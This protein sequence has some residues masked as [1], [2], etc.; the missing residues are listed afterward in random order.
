M[1]YFHYIFVSPFISHCSCCIIPYRAQLCSVWVTTSSTPPP[2]EVLNDSVRKYDALRL[3]YI[4]AYID[5]ML[6]C[7]RKD[8]VE[9]LLTWA[10]TSQQDLPSFY[11]ASAAFRGGDPGKHTKQSLL[12]G[13][14]FISIVK[15]RANNA[16]AEM[17]LNDLAK[18]KMNGVENEGKKLLTKNFK[19]SY[20]LFQRLNTSCED[21]V[22]FMQSTRPVLEV[23]A[24]C[25]CY[26]SV[27]AGYR[28]NDSINFDDMDE[29]S[30]CS[31]LKAA[32]SNAKDKF[33]RESK[34]KIPK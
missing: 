32:L 29:S 25:K 12:Q 10:T 33:Q 2:F 9:T 13:L 1:S 17:I 8:K 18:M 27:Q 6:I 15:R 24:L 26:V 14:G 3:K 20:T 28:I 19:L 16:L 22:R 21:V 30:L 5:S 31:L 4:N 23:A 34:L 11:E 7:N